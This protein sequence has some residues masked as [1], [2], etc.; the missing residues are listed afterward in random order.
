MYRLVAEI[1]IDGAAGSFDKCYTY[2]IPDT[3]LKTAQPGCRVT[4]PFGKGNIKKQGM[5]LSVFESETNEKTKEICSVTDKEPILNDEMITMCKWLK[6]HVF[7]TYFD[8]IHTMLPAG[9]NYRFNDFYLANDEF[10]SLII[11]LKFY[12]IVMFG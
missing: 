3:L 4:I 10:C 11:V 8:A 7:C 1:V 12:F 5:I 6:S 2:A 9:L